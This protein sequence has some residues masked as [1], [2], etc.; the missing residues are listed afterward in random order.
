VARAAALRP[1]AIQ[2]ILPDW[3]VV[4]DEEALDFLLMMR[5]RASGVPLVLYNP[6]HAKRVLSPKELGK[7]LRAVPKVVG[8][9]LGDGDADWYAAARE[10]LRGVS[11]FVPGHHL[12]TGVRNGVAAG[13]FSNVAC[14][15]PAAAQR[16][17]DSMESDLEAALELEGRICQFLETYIMPFK[18]DQG[19]SNAALDKLLAATGGWA[20]IGTRLRRPYRWID[21]AVAP[22]LRQLA[23]N[24]IPELVG[25]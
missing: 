23:H 4:S 15:N 18:V 24:I 14:I 5:E 6:P 10:H 17:W 25:A 2:V 7:L 13:A 3:V 16:W 19:Y 20:P 9:K 22:P 21:E 8:V 12:A 11:L 1:L